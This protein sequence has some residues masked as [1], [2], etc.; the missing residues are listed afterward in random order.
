MSTCRMVLIKLVWIIR[1]LA[2]PGCHV[3][4]TETY[5][6]SYRNAEAPSDSVVRHAMARTKFRANKDMAAVWSAIKNPLI[7]DYQSEILT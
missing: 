4:K 7:P 2:F 1:L 6:G 3:S 5:G